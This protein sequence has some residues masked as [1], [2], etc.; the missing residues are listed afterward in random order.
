M[1]WG[2][3]FAFKSRRIGT[4]HFWLNLPHHLSSCG[5][6]KC[7]IYELRSPFRIS[8]GVEARNLLSWGI[9]LKRLIAPCALLVRFCYIWVN[10]SSNASSRG[11][12]MRK[13]RKIL[14]ALL[15]HSF[16]ASS[17]FSLSGILRPT[18]GISVRFIRLFPRQKKN[19]C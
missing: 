16:G 3:F 8:N 19:R 5:G 6:D 17:K 11:C 1:F 12:H 13:T 4:R 15:T 9:S 2:V 7:F 18:S 10:T 14:P